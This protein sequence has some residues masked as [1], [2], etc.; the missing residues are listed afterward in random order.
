MKHI[1]ALLIKFIMVTVVLEIV[2][3][4]MT[5]LTFTEI[6]NIS[7]AVTLIAYAIGDL[8][9]LSSSNNTI[10]TVADFVLTLV[11]IYLSNY[12]LN[13]REISFTDAFVSALVLGIGE[14][15]FHKYIA[16]NVFPDREKG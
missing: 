16:R 9:I 8:Y 13:I 10:A 6:L 5:N 1:Y 7:I 3:S 4:L 11:T 2:L 14:W 12:I 15:I